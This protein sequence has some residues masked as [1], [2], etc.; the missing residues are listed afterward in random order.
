[1]IRPDLV[2]TSTDIKLP[3][4]SGHYLGIENILNDWILWDV[5]FDKQLGYFVAEKC[6]TTKINVMWWTD[7]KSSR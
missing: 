3:P 6:S 2:F 4:K 7:E 5:W 1:M